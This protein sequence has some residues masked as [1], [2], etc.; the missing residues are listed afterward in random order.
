MSANLWDLQQ[1]R[2]TKKKSG[3]NK[4]LNISYGAIPFLPANWLPQPQLLYNRWGD[5]L[6]QS[7]LINGLI[8]TWLA[9]GT[10]Q[11]VW[12]PE[13]GQAPSGIWTI[14]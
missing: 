2:M 10:L 13:P 14:N 9:L 12:I 5:T 8:S 4:I 3:T 1:N 7:M 11:R 6:T